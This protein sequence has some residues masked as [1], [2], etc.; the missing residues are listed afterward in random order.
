MW[1]EVWR[2][3]LS[4]LGSPGTVLPLQRSTGKSTNISA[5]TLK[6][7]RSTRP[8]KQRVLCRKRPVED[9]TRKSKGADMQDFE[10]N[11]DKQVRC[12]ILFVRF[13]WEIEGT[14][15]FVP[16]YDADHL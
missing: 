10:N 15:A 9:S 4:L 11:T 5:R 7:R 2:P 16:G 8:L 6:R 12:Q 1:L 3:C 13:A 14:Q